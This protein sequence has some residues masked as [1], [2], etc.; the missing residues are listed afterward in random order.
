MGSTSWA[1]ITTIGSLAAAFLVV[2]ALPALAPGAHAT[3]AT[4]PGSF[5]SAGQ[6]AYGAS[7]W[8]NVSSTSPNGTLTLHAFFGWQVIFNATNT[9][10]TTEQLEVERTA[11]ASL[12]ANFCSPNCTAPLIHGNLSIVGWERAAAFVN[13]TDAANVTVNGS[14]VPAYGILNEAGQFAGNLTESLLFTGTGPHGSVS[15]TSYFTVAASGSAQVAFSGALGILPTNLSSGESWT[16]SAAYNASGSW[17]ANALVA[18]TSSFGGNGSA[19]STP[20]GS[21]TSSGTVHVYGH[22]FGPLTLRDGDVNHGV[23]IAI[24]GPFELREGIVLVPGDLDLFASDATHPWDHDSL[25]ATS[26]ATDRIDIRPGHDHDLHL[27]AADSNYAGGAAS[28]MSTGSSTGLS[29]AASG[30]QPTGDL[31]AQP[32]S[33]PTAQ[34]SSDCLVGRCTAA[35]GPGLLSGGAGYL[36]LAGL[37]GALVV[38][39]VGAVSYHRWAQRRRAGAGPVGPSAGASALGGSPPSSP[40]S[41]PTLPGPDGTVPTTPGGPNFPR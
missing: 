2:L 22:D 38:G 1:R 6:W 39:T 3:P 11:A 7:T 21:V 33:V 25:G 9:S 23:A 29:P 41:A 28:V 18:H 40:G 20:S 35:A 30:A 26:F 34:H 32:E 36:L 13:I 17:S 8:N 10:A 14:S 19:R 24:T 4:G 12:F 15:A 31:Q 5:G 16:S 27:E 37:L